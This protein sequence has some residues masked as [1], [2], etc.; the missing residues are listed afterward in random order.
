MCIRV[1]TGLFR[2]QPIVEESKLCS[3]PKCVN[4]A[5]DSGIYL[6]S[7]YKHGRLQSC[8][9]KYNVKH[10]C[11]TKSSERYCCISYVW[12]IPVQLVKYFYYNI[13][14][15]V[16]WVNKVLQAYMCFSKQCQNHY[17]KKVVKESGIFNICYNKIVC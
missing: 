11:E 3:L 7:N 16:F 14:I 13:C 6:E 2:P 8:I 4:Q 1:Y 15:C 12:E 5:I 9:K 17:I 10:L